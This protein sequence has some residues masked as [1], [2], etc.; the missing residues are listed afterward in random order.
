[1]KKETCN[2]CG[3]KVEK[4]DRFRGLEACESCC[5]KAADEENKFRG[6]DFNM[7]GEI[8]LQ[9]E[10]SEGCLDEYNY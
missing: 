9:R 8:D 3:K 4:L 7:D 6:R 5:D 10:M 2:C 1:M